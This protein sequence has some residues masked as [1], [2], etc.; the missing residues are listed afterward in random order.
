MLSSFPLVPPP[1][2]LHE[3]ERALVE[4]EPLAFLHGNVDEVP[5]LR[6]LYQRNGRR[7][8][9]GSQ[10]HLGLMNRHGNRGRKRVHMTSNRSSCTMCCSGS[11]V[12]NCVFGA[13]GHLLHVP[14]V[15]LC[16]VKRGKDS[17]GI[18]LFKYLA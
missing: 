10:G 13:A 7:P 14:N 1:R 8:T 15:E 5:V 6:E 16:R 12:E 9:G 3:E 17:V 4:H 18:G 11:R 2:G